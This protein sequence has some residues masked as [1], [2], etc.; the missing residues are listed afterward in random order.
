MA[1]NKTEKA[2]DLLNPK[3]IEFKYALGDLQ[4]LIKSIARISH[5]LSQQNNKPIASR[6]M[7]FANKVINA[8]EKD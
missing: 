6:L 5:E 4:E 2:K 3:P 1:K 8:E 7:K